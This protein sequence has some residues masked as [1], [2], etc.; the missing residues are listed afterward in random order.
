MDKYFNR[1]A[2]KDGEKMDEQAKIED[3]EMIQLPSCSSVR[4]G[5]GKQDWESNKNIWDLTQ[6]GFFHKQ[7][8]KNT[9]TTFLRPTFV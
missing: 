6:K 2:V 1:M 5:Q 9:D 8:D 3:G 4:H 7:N